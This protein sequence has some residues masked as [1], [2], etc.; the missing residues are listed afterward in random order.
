M[1][2]QFDGETFERAGL[3]SQ[4]G[5]LATCAGH[6]VA[7]IYV[8]AEVQGQKWGVNTTRCSRQ[9]LLWEFCA[10]AADLQGG[11]PRLRVIIMVGGNVP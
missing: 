2:L 11:V 1:C 9:A 8:E 6:C 7:V 3:L 5:G 10:C 4:Q